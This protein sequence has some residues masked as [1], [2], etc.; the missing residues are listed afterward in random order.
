MVRPRLPKKSKSPPST[1][2]SSS[3]LGDGFGEDEGLGVFGGRGLLVGPDVSV[4]LGWGDV[5]GGGVRVADRETGV[6][7]LTSVA[8][9]V[10]LE[11]AALGVPSGVSSGDPEE[12]AG[13]EPHVDVADPLG[14]VADGEAADGEGS[15]AACA[16]GS[17]SA[18][19]V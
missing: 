17:R 4:P 9:V 12:P 1:E 13:S 15:T 8:A 5:V 2:S 16:A 10:A 6:E 19:S 3:P 7:R 11:S 18:S 14:V